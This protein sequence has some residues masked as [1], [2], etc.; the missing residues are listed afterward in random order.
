MKLISLIK[1]CRPKQWTKNLLCFSA[2]VITPFSDDFIIKISFATIAFILASSSIYLIND[3]LDVEQDKLHPRKKF[4]PIASG[5]VKVWE[6][7]ILFFICI[8]FSLFLAIN[9]SYIFSGIILTYF[10]AQLFYCFYGKN[11]I[12]FDIYLIALGFVLRALGGVFSLEAA[13][14]PWFLITSGC[15]ALFLAIQKRKSELSRVS[16]NKI[17]SRK[18]LKIYSLNYL[19]K[20]E[21]L[22][23]NSGFISYMLWA[24]GPIFNG[25]QSSNMLITCPILLIGINRYQLISMRTKKDILEGESP[26]QILFSDLPIKFIVVSLLFSCWLITNLS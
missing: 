4:R 3:I 11:I 23:L 17:I 5:E 25:A 20:I 7:K 8:L 6:A 1:A 10:F 18:V 14:S 9:I 16:K 26:T 13:P 2:I 24:S 19:D 15:M 12:L 22:A 21:M